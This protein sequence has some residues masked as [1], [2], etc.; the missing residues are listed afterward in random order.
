MISINNRSSIEES[1]A[2]DASEVENSTASAFTSDHSTPDGEESD[3]D[4]EISAL[5]YTVQK[6]YQQFQI[7]HDGCT[8]EQHQEKLDQYINAVGND[9]YGLNDIFNDPSFPS[10]LALPDLISVERLTREAA[11]TPAQWQTTFCGISPHQQSPRQRPMHVCLHKEVAQA[12]E[13]DIAFD[14]DSFLG[15]FRSLT[16]ARQG[17]YYRP[18][19]QMR[20]NITTDVHLHTNI[21]EQLDD[22]E[23][24]PQ[25]SL[26]MLKDVPHFLLGRVVGAENITVH[27]L[28]PHLAL[29]Q[30][31]FVSL[32]REQTSRWLDLIFHPTIYRACR[33]HY[34]QHLPAS[35]RHALANSKS[36]QVE[37]RQIRTASYE[38]QQS[39]SHILQPAYLEQIW[40]DV[41]NTIHHTPGLMDFREPQLFFS[42][43]GTK[44]L[45][46]TN[47]LRPTLL[48]AMESFQSYLERVIDMDLIFEDRFYVDLG[49]EICPYLGLCPTQQH[50]L[51]D[52]AQIY[53]WKR[54]CLEHYIH[55]MYDGN[56]P[57]QGGQGQR[58]YDQNML[59]DASSLTSVTPKQSKLREGGII[60]SQ[61]YG[62]IKEISDAMKRYPFD[63]D[64]L[65]ELALDPQIRQGARHLARGRR[66]DVKIVERAYLASK[67]RARHALRDS[68][69]KSFGIREEHRITWTLFQALLARL[70]LEDPEDWDIVISGCPSYA[71]AVNT[72]VYLD[73][74]WR[75]ADKFATGFEVVRAHCHRDLIT[76]EQTKMMAMFLRCLRF[77][78]GG[79]QLQRES[80]LWWSRREL[81]TRTW[82]GLGFCNTLPRYKYCWLEPRLDWSQLTFQ[83]EIAD[84]V[85]FGN[86]MLRG[87]Y[88]RR[89]GQ[90]R[91]F[92]DA[93]RQLELALTWMDRHHQHEEIRKQLVFR[94]IQICLQQFRIDVLSNVKSEISSIHR[95]EALQGT[96][97]F[98]FDYL[99][100]IMT[101]GVYLMSGN[102][103]DFK[104]VSNLVHYLFDFEDGRI[105]TH[106]EDRPFRK[107]YRRA[108]TALDLRHGG[109]ELGATFSRRLGR[110]LVSQHW[111]LPYPFSDG[112]MQT[113][114]EG[115][116]M[117]Y[118]IQPKATAS[119]SLNYLSLDMWEWARKSWRAG[120]PPAIHQSISWS[121]EEWEGWIGRHQTHLDR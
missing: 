8:S 90:I 38:G 3:E 26:A 99:D 97:P 77:V 69:R 104:A 58:Y 117:W 12:I 17:I 113:T 34:T 72:D 29:T 36:H 43:K 74:L 48:E 23:Q 20:Q 64:G 13:T 24:A 118:S 42:A 66:R 84:Q 94:M 52:Q 30:E 4:V 85:L 119:G 79:H 83:E 2:P 86:Q 75:S 102:R 33:A 41:L 92:F 68:R 88:L 63:N 111:I 112:L 32:T 1:I 56:P 51:E 62:S 55:A 47:P 98:S 100:Q 115:K 21:Y 120:S 87:H 106:W 108:R 44:L 6:L 105:R 89:G 5:D 39:I 31:K 53:S 15:Y 28:F 70:R 109:L 95:D 40:T 110:Q 19:S 103:C 91:D 16:A 60:Y 93:T 57:A 25:A 71:W 80:A 107:L 9:H 59:Y 101:A 18:A 61:F 114:K 67:E 121:K 22:P 65:E 116:R 49:K 10:V 81:P 37:G 14:I 11:P 96:E 27:I 54:C 78:F 50:H 7:G 46:K 73:F 76:W 45:F 82:Y 35:H